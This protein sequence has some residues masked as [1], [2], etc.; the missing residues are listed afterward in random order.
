MN[1]H[2]FH[3]EVERPPCG[4]ARCDQILHHFVL[5]VDGNSPAGQFCEIDTMT[6]SENVDVD[7]VMRHA[8]ALKTCADAVL[9][10]EVNGRLLENSGASPLDDVVLRTVLDDEGVD[11]SEMEEV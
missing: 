3:F 7:A 11:S 5:T 4:P 1:A 2:I 6:L 9:D 10:D 8:L